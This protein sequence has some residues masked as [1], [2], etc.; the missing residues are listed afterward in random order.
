MPDAEA[1]TDEL[2]RAIE[3]LET[4]VQDPQRVA[5]LPE[6]DRVRLMAAAGR[7]SRPSKLKK[8][9]L[10]HRMRKER[11]KQARQAV[12]ESDR[13]VR[14]ETGIREARRAEVFAAPAFA[15][16][17]PEAP[18]R[19]T[20]QPRSCYV[21]KQPFTRLHHFYD[22]L[23]AACGDLNYAKRFQT[24]DLSGRT[25]YITGARVKIGYHAALMLL[26][27]GARVIV[28]TRFP[29]DAARRYASEKDFPRWGD[30][31]SIHGLDLRHSPSV[32]IFAR[33]LNQT[34][35]RMDLLVSNAAQTVRR[36]V[37]FY[38]HLLE[39]ETRSWRELPEPERRIL[40][41]HYACVAALGPPP[42]APA[43]AG[44]LTSWDGGAVGLGLRESA[45]LSQVRMT[46]DDRTC[47]R[48]LFPER[49]LDADLQQVDLRTWN[50]WRMTLAEVPTPELLEVLLINAVAPFILAARLKPLLLK[51][52]TGAVHVVNVSAMEGVFSRGPK[53]DKHPHTN[54][55]KAAL[56]MMTR[57][58]AS[59]YARDG[60][61][62]NAVDTGW[63]T[64]EDPLV[65]AARKEVDHD[66]QPPLDVVDGAA[67]ILDPFFA[68]LR[69][70]VHAHGQFF[71]DYQ[72]SAW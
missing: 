62:M 21:C 48:D 66:F 63:V 23:C 16:P 65:H 47:G 44:A 59:D 64:D 28:S 68:G 8:L 34:E 69:T 37:A 43:E 30:R 24:A 11:R 36:P 7:I 45:R 61:W 31:L 72:P 60:I 19:E 67:R 39:G 3:L 2:L 27:A 71:K 53:T 42:D 9:R 32:E 13:A 57:T 29:H 52:A 70:G 18:V 40:E 17:G 41:G 38:R 1:T 58:S 33:Y 49:R 22:R 10:T 25:A 51:P 5:A 46:Y 26:R 56:N 20:A 55:A 6:P 35:S 54:M 12:R 14:A 50:T 4:L 15:L